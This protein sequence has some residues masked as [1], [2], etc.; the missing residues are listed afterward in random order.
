MR[1]NIARMR[2]TNQARGFVG[3]VLFSSVDFARV[4]EHYWTAR[5]DAKAN[6]YYVTSSGI[7]AK[8]NAA[9]LLHRWL[10]RVAD[11]GVLVDHK[12]HNTLDNR[13]PNLRRAS[14][15]QNQQNRR[16]ANRNSRSGIRGVSPRVDGLWQADVKADNRR[17]HGVYPTLVAAAEAAQRMRRVMARTNTT[18]EHTKFGVAF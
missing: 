1:G 11:S 8:G 10:L 5:W 14:P 16:G 17:W 3:E 12:N 4:R 7:R 2:V 18:K 6:A 15:A 9:G 13:R